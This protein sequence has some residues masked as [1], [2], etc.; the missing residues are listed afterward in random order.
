MA[1]AEPEIMRKASV[2][3]IEAV[4]VDRGRTCGTRSEAEGGGQGI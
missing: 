4:T 2:K 3:S 1:R